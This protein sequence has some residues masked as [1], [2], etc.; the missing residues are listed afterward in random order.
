MDIKELKKSIENKSP[1]SFMIWKMTDDSSMFIAKQYLRQLSE[2][3]GLPIVYIDSLDEVSDSGL[4][5]HKNYTVF[6]TNEFNGLDK[7]ADNLIVICDKSSDKNYINFPALEK[8]QFIDYISTV[9]PGVSKDDLEWLITQYEFTY[10]RKTWVRY[11]MFY[12]DMMKIAIY[13]KEEQ[14][15]IFDYLYDSG[16]YSTISNLTIFDLSN[17]IMRKDPKLALEV[18]KVFPYIDSKPEIWLLSILLNNFKKVIDIQLNPFASAADLGM[19]DKQYYAVKKNN[20]GVYSNKEL[21]DIYKELT[22]V[23]YQYKFEGLPVSSVV[24]YLICRILGR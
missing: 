16:E 11:F 10:S 14:Q 12:N 20:I 7:S 24:D 8:W 6:V 4:F 17:A 21:I 19:S 15:K 23:E 3:T 9:V 22:N 5:G 18:L 2:N 1:M 13:P